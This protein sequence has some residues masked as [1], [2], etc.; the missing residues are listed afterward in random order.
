[1]Y[2]LYDVFSYNRDVIVKSLGIEY[3]EINTTTL[4]MLLIHNLKLYSLLDRD[5]IDVSNDTNFYNLLQLSSEELLLNSDSNLYNLN[6][7]K[8]YMLDL[9]LL[10]LNTESSNNLVYKY[11]SEYARSMLNI[12]LFPKE[13]MY[14]IILSTTDRDLL[15]SYYTSNKEHKN[16]IDNNLLTIINNI[17]DSEPLINLELKISEM[18]HIGDD[19]KTFVDLLKFYDTYYYSSSPSR[20]NLRYLPRCYTIAKSKGEISNANIILNIIKDSDYRTTHKFYSY[21]PINDIVEIISNLEDVMND[22]YLLYKILLN[23]LEEYTSEDKCDKITRDDNEGS[24]TYFRHFISHMLGV[25]NILSF[26]NVGSCDENC[27]NLSV[28]CLPLF[29]MFVSI[30]NLHLEYPYNYSIIHSSLYHASITTIQCSLLHSR[31]TPN[32]LK[33]VYNT[34]L[35]VLGKDNNNGVKDITESFLSSSIYNGTRGSR[36]YIVNNDM[37]KEYVKVCKELQL[38]RTSI[39]KA[40][41]HAGSCINNLDQWI[42]NHLDND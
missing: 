24:V 42:S 1:M 6:N 35:S 10:T 39:E 30:L 26:M 16:L 7:Y 31:Y 23:T 2:T 15:V 29:K 11:G 3:S 20:C 36:L 33:R 9:V 28:K 19:V 18:R 4:R 25:G 13:I 38:S 27:I 40:L 37:V 32:E 41:R 12:Q 34:L 14:K 17:I 22:K 5:S 21:V 8:M